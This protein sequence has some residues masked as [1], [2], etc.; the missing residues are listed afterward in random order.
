MGHP[1]N[2]LSRHDMGMNGLWR[3]VYYDQSIHVWCGVKRVHACWGDCLLKNTCPTLFHSGRTNNLLHL[4]AH[5][6]HKMMNEMMNWRSTL[7]HLFR[8]CLTS[9]H[10]HH[11]R[12]STHGHFCGITVTFSVTS[13]LTQTGSNCTVTFIQLRVSWIMLLVVEH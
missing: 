1:S 6:R 12:L 11:T 7:Q 5:P 10:P 13:N 3:G 2:R 9:K 4:W 8:E